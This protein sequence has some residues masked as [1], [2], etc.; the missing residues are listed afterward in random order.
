M[1]GKNKSENVKTHL[2]A[3]LG[4]GKNI[5]EGQRAKKVNGRLYNAECPPKPNP[6]SYP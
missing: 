5:T 2:T 6:N 4:C 3:C 1:P